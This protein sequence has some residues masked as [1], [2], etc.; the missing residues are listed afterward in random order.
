MLNKSSLI[1]ADQALPGRT[2]RIE[3]EDKHFIHHTP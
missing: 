1:S 2:T 3:F